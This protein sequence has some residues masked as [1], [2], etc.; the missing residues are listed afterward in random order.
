MADI[1]TLLNDPDFMALPEEEQNSFID[2]MRQRDF[3]KI[4]KPQN[5]L[6]RA[7]GFAGK[8]VLEAT[9]MKAPL[10]F[11]KFNVDNPSMLPITGG[12]GGTVVGSMFG[13][14]NVGAG[15]GTALG[16]YGKEALETARGHGEFDAVGPTVSGATAYVGGK[17]LEKAVPFVASKLGSV[18]KNVQRLMSSKKALKFSNKLEGAIESEGSNLSTAM[19]KGIDDV[20]KLYP[21]TRVSF[22]REI[23]SPKFDVKLNKLLDK[24]EALKYYDLDNLT[25]KESQEVI[26]SLK[27]NLR[28]S[29]KT[30]D[31]VK[32][33]ERGI[34]D[35][36]NQLRSKQLSTFPEHSV[37]LKNYGEGIEAYKDV[38]GDIPSMMESKGMNRIE[39]AAKEQSLKR[40]SPEAHKEYRGFRNTKK[41]AKGLGYATG[42][43]AAIE[44]GR[45]VL[46][47]S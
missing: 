22:S 17:V 35:A 1:D 38:A 27:A 26:N 43:G 18:S 8:S 29:L 36:L 25:L 28:Q 37:N 10:E 46:G 24:S 7:A 45:R 30:G 39:R 15:V 5:V 40:I 16:G 41:T 42:I 6:Q 3:G 47:G 11:A 21:D 34:L 23:N 2:E 44:G 19:G 32:S 33:D 12:V 9:N 31:V 13:A 4:Q 14:P 20:Q